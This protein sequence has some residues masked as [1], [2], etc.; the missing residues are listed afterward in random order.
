LQ[1]ECGINSGWCISGGK[2]SHLL[3]KEL[4]NQK[5]KPSFSLGP[6]YSK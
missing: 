1:S 5:R 6:Q 3:R 2:H 4:Y